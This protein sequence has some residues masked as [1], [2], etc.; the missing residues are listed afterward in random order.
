MI[1]Q[2]NNALRDISDADFLPRPQIEDTP[3]H[4]VRFPGAHKAMNR[5]AHIGEIPGGIQISKMNGVFG[6][7]LSDNGWNDSPRRLPRPKGVEG[8]HSDHRQVIGAIKTFNHFV[9][10]DLAG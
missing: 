3:L 7:R 8:A 6:Q 10:A 5:V 2:P 9:G 4:T 1:H